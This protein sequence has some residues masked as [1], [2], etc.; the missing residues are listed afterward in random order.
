MN[1]APEQYEDCPDCG[2]L[3]PGFFNRCL[4]CQRKDAIHR[5]CVRNRRVLLAFGVLLVVLLL[6]TWV[7]ADVQE[8]CIWTATGMDAAV[9]INP[10]VTDH[11]PWV[12]GTSGPILDSYAWRWSRSGGSEP[13]LRYA[14]ATLPAHAVGIDSGGIMVGW[15]APDCMAADMV[16]WQVTKHTNMPTYL[17]GGRVA[18]TSDN[19]VRTGVIYPD[20][21]YHYSEWRGFTVEPAGM[22]WLASPTGGLGNMGCSVSA[23]G[24]TVYGAAWTSATEYHA[25]KWTDGMPSWL[26]GVPADENSSVRDCSPDGEWALI[27]YDYDTHFYWHAGVMHEFPATMTGYGSQWSGVSDAGRFV[28]T[29]KDPSTNTIRAAIWEP[30]WTEPVRI[31]DIF[32][33]QL[34]QP[35]SNWRRLD[36][37]LDIDT[38]GAWVTGGGKL[39]NGDNAG[40]VAYLP[41][42]VPE[43]TSLTL[44]LLGA[45]LTRRKRR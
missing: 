21:Y 27:R 1:E 14:S 17:V 33:E 15:S 18:D 16:S 3:V 4:E 23:D 37:G 13:I 12:A 19:R 24:H 29:W 5:K 7:R 45:L 43:P 22:H 20:N 26:E 25:T 2:E 39:S 9:A 41:E 32:R 42:I 40:F 36:G 34:G 11:Q 44:L 10:Y 31:L 6:S 28:G 8:P 35:W 38:S 30:G